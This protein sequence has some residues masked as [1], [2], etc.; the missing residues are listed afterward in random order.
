[1]PGTDFEN[2]IEERIKVCEEKLAF[3]AIC[4]EKETTKVTGKPDQNICYLLHKDE[5]VYKFCLT[6]L[7]L[8]KLKYDAE[9]DLRGYMGGARRCGAGHTGI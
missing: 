4:K 7:N 3:I 9:K 5:A 8:L 2:Y 1:M 6:E